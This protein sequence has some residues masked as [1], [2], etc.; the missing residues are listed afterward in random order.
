MNR[1]DRLTGIIFALQSGRRST[2]GQLAA[3]FDVSRRTIL[4]DIDALCE[5]GVPI[6]SLPGAG[7]GFELHDDHWLRPIQLSQ[8]EAAALLLAARGLGSHP[9]A[10]LSVAAQA[11]VDKLRGVLRP[12]I[13]AA[14]ERDLAAI[15]VEPPRHAHRLRHFT[16]VRDAIER[17]V[18][19]RIGYQSLRRV[20]EHTI[21]PDSLSVREGFWYCHAVSRDARARRQYRLDRIRSVYEIPAPSDAE[22][23]LAAAHAPRISYHDPSHPEVVVCL[24][25]RGARLAEDLPNLDAPLREA[26]PDRWELRFRCP[27]A[28][29]PYYAR[30]FLGFG[31][32]MKILAPPELRRMVGDMARATAGLHADKGDGTVSPSGR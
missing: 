26:G 31:P 22:E 14:A 19:L 24:T 18:W 20:A 21:R 5:I 7:G 25:Y 30:A 28:E 15:D 27:P 9:D 8:A 3:R 10:P 6:V 2:A 13:V 12:E 17:G 23:V 32:E 4:R 1:T 29:L 11:A 16:T